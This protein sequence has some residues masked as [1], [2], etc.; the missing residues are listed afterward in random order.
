MSR[1]VGY[2]RRFDAAFKEARRAVASGE[3]G[4]IHTV[5][6][7]TLDP[8][9]PPDEYIKTSGGIYRDCAVHDFDAI[10]FVLGQDVVEVYAVGSTRELPCRRVW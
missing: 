8:A 9:P 6:S 4:F 2:S 3:L 5:R 1:S 10:R 7:T